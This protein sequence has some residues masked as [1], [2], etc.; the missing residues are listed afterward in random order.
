MRGLLVIISCLLAGQS[1]IGKSYA[2][3]SQSF[4]PIDIPFAVNSSYF[5]ER[6]AQQLL[7]FIQKTPNSNGYL[8]L[9]FP[10][11]REGEDLKMQEYN[12]WL[13]NRRIERVKSYLTQADVQSPII[14]RLLTA[15]QE[16]S[17]TVSLHWCP[18]TQDHI[19]LTDNSNL[20]NH[21]E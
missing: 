14:T 2:Q 12:L 1:V 6:Y 20:V 15:S 11:N 16:D 17:R 3:C 13:A 9:E 18:Q 5:A 21:A 8:L 10:L 19:T 7:Q 4:N